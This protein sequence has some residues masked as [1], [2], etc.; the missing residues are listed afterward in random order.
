MT[1]TSDNDKI[2]EN[3]TSVLH[4]LVNKYNVPE[5]VVN[6][7]SSTIENLTE[8]LHNFQ[9]DVDSELSEN[10]DIMVDENT[11]EISGKLVTTQSNSSRSDKSSS[12]SSCGSSSGSSVSII[13]FTCDLL[14]DRYNI[15]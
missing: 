2:F 15:L 13:D 8:T 5:Q 7:I 10:H 14:K 6:K 12:G 1:S 3:S 4:D 9:A 11:D